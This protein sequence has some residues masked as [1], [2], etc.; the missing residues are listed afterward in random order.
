MEVPHARSCET[1][2]WPGVREREGKGQVNGGKRKRKEARKGEQGK[3]KYARD[4]GKG[5][6]G[7]YVLLGVVS[8][9]SW[10]AF[11]VVVL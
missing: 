8:S 3:K 9:A 2:V 5:L 6:P 10:W 11:A 4:V 7:D 1:E